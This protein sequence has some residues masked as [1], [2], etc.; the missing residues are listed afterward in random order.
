MT[1]FTKPIL[2]P[3][4]ESD[5]VRISVM[6]RHTFNDGITPNPEIIDGIY[7]EWHPELAPDEKLLGDY[8]K[9]GLSWNDFAE[10]Y[11]ESLNETNRSRMVKKLAS[12]A[13]SQDV[14]IMCIEET[15]E[16]CHRRLLAEECQR[17]EP[18]LKI[19]IY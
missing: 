1:L 3:I 16:Y 9:R 17:I 12:Q 15:P 14:T 2:S 8:Y 13:L 5:G 11:I 6:S 4:S 19:E 7:D 10:A 18:D